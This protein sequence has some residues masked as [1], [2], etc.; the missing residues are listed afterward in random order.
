MNEGLAQTIFTVSMIP[1]GC[2]G[3]RLLLKERAVGTR[4]IAIGAVT[5]LNASIRFSDFSLMGILVR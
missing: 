5:S 2:Y 4:S 3:V 1:I